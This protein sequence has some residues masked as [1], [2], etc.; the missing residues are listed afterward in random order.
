MAGDFN[1]DL[2]TCEQNKP[3]SEYLNSLLT[4][5][6]LP[7]ILMPTRITESTAT[8][9]DHMHYYAGTNDKRSISIRSGNLVHDLTDHLPNYMLCIKDKVRHSTDR[10]LIIFFPI[11][12]FRNLKAAFSIWTGPQSI[13]IEMLILPMMLST[14]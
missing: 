7:A 12:I 14:I 13:F 10:P 4:N 1:I 11:L 8:L 9:I 6:F 3:T 5:N 2:T